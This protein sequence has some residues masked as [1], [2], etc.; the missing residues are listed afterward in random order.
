MSNELT[1]QERIEKLK[2]SPVLNDI[3]KKHGKGTI[4]LGEDEFP[5]VEI[6]CS[7][8]SLSLDIATG[9]GGFPKGRIIE[10]S[11]WESCL[12]ENTFVGFLLENNK[13]NKLINRK[14][15]TIKNLHDRFHNKVTHKRH[16]VPK[17]DCNFFIMSVNEENR[18]VRN[19]IN[20]VVYCGEKPCYK[21]TDSF[22][23]SLICT[24]DHEFMT[25]DGYKPLKELKKG[26]IIYIHNNTPYKS[27]KNQN[28]IRPEISVKYHPYWPIKKVNGCL[29]FRGRESRAT[30]E[31]HLN[32]MTF[33]E[34]RNFLNTESKEKIDTLKFLDC[35]IHI[36]HKDENFKNNSIDNLE[37]IDPKSH[38][39]LHATE[40]HNNLRFIVTESTI[41]NIEFVGNKNTYDIKCA[42]PY[43]NY[44]ANNFVVH[45]CGKSTLTLITIAEC[46]RNNKVCAYLDIEQA[47]D[48]TYAQKLGVDTDNLLISQPENMEDTFDILHSLINSKM[49]DYI[50]V[51]STNAMLI[52]RISD[53]EVGESNM[54][55]SGLI[56]SQE[57]PKVVVGCSNTGCTVIFIS[58]LRSKIGVTF[59]SNEVIGV[60]NAMRFQASIRIKVSKSE[61]VKSDDEGQESIDINALI[62]KNKVSAPYKKATFTLLTGKDGLY[63]IDIYKEILDYAVKFEIVKKAG[64][65]FSYGEEKWQGEKNVCNFLRQNDIVF[66][67]IKEKVI[68]KIKEKNDKLAKPIEGSFADIKAKQEEEKKQKKKSKSG[69]P[70]MEEIAIESPAVEE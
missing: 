20:D 63:G 28:M 10:I 29:Y 9:I 68:Q 32:N 12:E 24:E 41:T 23:K 47:F 19:K 44:V 48:P 67:E 1:L 17:D 35:N 34:Y 2:K 15:G 53:G 36:H 69:E 59:G 31:A 25:K 51:D 7:T 42:P 55:R 22:G 18:I 64:A 30:Y 52:K 26:D 46:Q 61:Q 8:G 4:I 43:N 57:L 37:L 58:Q 16:I 38:G 56:M 21:I 60:G 66:K 62:F 11:G 40:R 3:E 49:V 5:V 14:G 70:E 6:L 13:T 65:W 33:E 50:I 27:F 45:N 39:V 54:G